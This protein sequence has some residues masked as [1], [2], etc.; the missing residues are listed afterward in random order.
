MTTQNMFVLLITVFQ[1][2]L[3]EIEVDTRRHFLL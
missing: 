3:T 2:S 1:P